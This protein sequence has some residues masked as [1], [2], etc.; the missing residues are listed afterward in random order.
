MKETEEEKT[1]TSNQLVS[2]AQLVIGGYWISYMTNDSTWLFVV[3]LVI[4]P[5]A[6][7]EL[8]PKKSF[9]WQRSD[10]LMADV[11]NNWQLSQNIWGWNIFCQRAKTLVLRKCVFPLWSILSTKYFSSETS[12]PFHLQISFFE[13]L[14]LFCWQKFLSTASNHCIKQISFCQSWFILLANAFCNT[15]FHSVERTHKSLSILIF[16]EVKVECKSS[17]TA[18]NMLN[19]STSLEYFKYMW[20]N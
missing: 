15:V 13:S 14:N 18:A 20:L 9:S 12:K 16:W 2:L 10:W 8:L 3:V 1:L 11:Q 6:S 7:T 4:P 17:V 5:A 19:L